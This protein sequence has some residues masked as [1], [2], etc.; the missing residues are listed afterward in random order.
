VPA[1]GFI[2]VSQGSVIRLAK[3]LSAV[4]TTNVSHKKKKELISELKLERTLP[5]DELKEW[6]R[7]E[8]LISHKEGINKQ[9]H[10]VCTDRKNHGMKPA[11]QGRGNGRGQCHGGT[12]TW[13]SVL[14]TGGTPAVGPALRTVRVEQP[15]LCFPILPASLRP[16]LQTQPAAMVG[17]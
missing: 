13:G 12:P 17:S 4:I 3:K 6:K 15:S 10:L 9:Y 14:R 2:A 8:N 5:P 11:G 16:A 1:K 7:E